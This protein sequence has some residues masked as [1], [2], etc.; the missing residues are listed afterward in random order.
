MEQMASIRLPDFS[1]NNKYAEYVSSY[2]TLWYIVC[3]VYLQHTYRL[4]TVHISC[5]HTNNI[6]LISVP[7]GASLFVDRVPKAEQFEE[8]RPPAPV[9]DHEDQA[10]PLSLVGL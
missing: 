6:D 4:P 9:A 5:I 8:A 1:G 3:I 10:H 7:Q 2:M